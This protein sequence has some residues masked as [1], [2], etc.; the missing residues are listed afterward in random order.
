MRKNYFV[1]ASLLMLVAC[2]KKE[3]IT[4][5]TY[6]A[7]V[8]VAVSNLPGTPETD[9]YLDG[10]FVKTVK[11]GQDYPSN[12]AKVVAGSKSKL[13]LY[14]AGTKNLIADS[15]IDISKNTLVKVNAVNCEQL[16]FKGWL[17]TTKVPDDIMSMQLF[18]NLPEKYPPVL[19]MHIFLA[20]PITIET[21]ET[22]IVLQNF[23]RNK[24]H[25]TR[26]DLP[27]KYNPDGKT[28]LYVCKLKVPG[29]NEWILNEGLGLD[30]IP[31]TWSDGTNEGKF[32]IYSIVDE[33]DYLR[34]DPTYL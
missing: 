3:A 28:M 25:P 30:I 4:E 13:S 5:R 2:S 7:E 17:T 31:L 23:T 15:V 1:M 33:Q 21:A 11:P 24:L 26:L 18:D 16:G 20:D 27:V 32:G 12:S 34:A 6:Y 14:S 19:E 9:I 22:G 10:V 29:S 8:S